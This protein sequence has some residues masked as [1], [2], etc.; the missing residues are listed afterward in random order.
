MQHFRLLLLVCYPTLESFMRSLQMF[1]CSPTLPP[2]NVM[3]ILQTAQDFMQNCTFWYVSP[4]EPQRFYA[5]FVKCPTF[6]LRTPLR[7]ASKI[8]KCFC[9]SATTTPKISSKICGLSYCCPIQ[10]PQDFTRS[11]H[12]WVHVPSPTPHTR[13]LSSYGR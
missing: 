6:L 10:P 12:F 11:L 7:T 1:L 2:K 8:C 4:G 13:L 3:Q 9:F 5:N